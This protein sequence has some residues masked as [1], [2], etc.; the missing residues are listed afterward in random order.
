MTREAQI[1][2]FLWIAT[3]VVAHAL[4]G[5]GADR[6][7]QV[8]EEKIEIREFA[9]SVRRFVRGDAKTVEIALLDEEADPKALD[10]TEPPAPE[11]RTND[12][13]DEKSA[14]QDE[15]A[16]DKPK[17]PLPEPKR[18]PDENKPPEE[19]KPEEKK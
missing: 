4:W 19:K 18:A 14:D 11:P 5:G 8:I 10:P 3:A 13:P 1:P 16:P 6:A 15:A 17:K 12:D 9:A 7:A 2:L